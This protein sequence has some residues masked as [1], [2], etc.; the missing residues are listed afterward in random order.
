MELF[1]NQFIKE[2][3]ESYLKHEP[4][5]K[6]TPRGEPIGFSREKY[7]AMLY[8]M[9]G[10]KLKDVAKLFNISY[11]IVR[12]WNTEEQFQKA[13]AEH[14]WQFAE[15]L[16]TY[17]QKQIQKEQ[18]FLNELTEGPIDKVIE[19]KGFAWKPEDLVKDYKYYHPQLKD[20]LTLALLN[21]EKP[22]DIAFNIIIARLCKYLLRFETGKKDSPETINAWSNVGKTLNKQVITRIRKIHLKKRITDT[23]RKEA[24]LLLNMLE[25]GL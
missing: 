5:R 19:F 8:V 7:K 21:P 25:Q 18:K 13:I 20:A 16:I 14:S 22:K 12:R 9:R 15:Y 4:R 11:Q 23:D 24:M 17:L 2:K 10:F 3:Y 6:G 1:I